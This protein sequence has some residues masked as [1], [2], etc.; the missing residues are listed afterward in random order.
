MKGLR[1]RIQLSIPKFKHF[2]PHSFRRSLS[3]HLAEENIPVPAI[4]NIMRH[5][6]EKI[7][8]KYYIERTDR[9]IQQAVEKTGGLVTTFQVFNSQQS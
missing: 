7:T 6:S 3:T 4:K 1:E 5:T 2:S 9:M 8:L